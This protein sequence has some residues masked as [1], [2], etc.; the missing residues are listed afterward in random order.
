MTQIVMPAHTNGPAGALFGGMVMQWID[1][2]AGVAAM[3]H[4]GGKVVTASIDRLDFLSPIF[5]GDVVTLRSRV[6]FTA[7][8]SMELGVQVQTE[9]PGSEE[10]RATTKAYLTF[11][12]LDEDGKPRPVPPLQLQSD[13]DRRRYAEAKRRR[14]E[15]LRLS[16]RKG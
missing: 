5:V 1:I 10:R 6:N 13:E 3:R 9:H 8:T 12:Y 2:C 7:R 11:V 15:R 14:D 16:G 4:C